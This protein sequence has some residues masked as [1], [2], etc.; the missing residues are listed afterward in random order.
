MSGSPLASCL[1]HDGAADACPS[2]RFAAPPKA[3][4]V[5]HSCMSMANA[6]ASFNGVILGSRRRCWFC[7]KGQFLMDFFREMRVQIDVYD[8][9]NRGGWL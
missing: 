5:G 9:A 2:P 3:K 7:Q 1:G 8:N 6:G 4:A